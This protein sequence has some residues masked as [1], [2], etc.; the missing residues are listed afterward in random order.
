M[1]KSINDAIE[2]IEKI[3]EKIDHEIKAA[4][5]ELLEDD[6]ALEEIIK[7]AGQAQEKLKQCKSSIELRERMSDSPDDFQKCRE[8]YIVYANRFINL[9]ATFY[10]TLA[11][12]QKAHRVRLQ[13][14]FEDIGQPKQDDELDELVKSKTALENCLAMT[15]QVELRSLFIETNRARL[16]KLFKITGQQNVEALEEKFETEPNQPCPQLAEIKSCYEDLINLVKHLE[17]MDQVRKNSSAFMIMNAVPIIKGAKKT[18]K[19]KIWVGVL[20][21]VCIV[22][23]LALL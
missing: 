6:E 3:I 5:Q 17:N 1:H 11:E 18:K 14:L 22:L 8:K 4:S 15:S 16:Q 10:E 19:T 20:G 7:N 21:F 2:I 9:I 23:F 13:R 12:N